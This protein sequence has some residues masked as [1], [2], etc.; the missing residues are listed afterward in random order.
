MDKQ[1]VLTLLMAA[2]ISFS[3]GY[4]GFSRNNANNL[5]YIAM[6]SIK[7][8]T[9]ATFKDILLGYNSRERKSVPRCIPMT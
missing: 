7:K 2:T 1:K 9:P 3:C 5:N 8:Y 6:D 4:V